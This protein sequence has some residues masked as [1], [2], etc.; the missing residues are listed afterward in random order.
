MKR[1]A[2]F[3]L[4]VLA[5]LVASARGP[6][7]LFPFNVEDGVVISD[8]ANKMSHA[9]ATLINKKGDVFVAHI[10][11]CQNNHEDPSNLTIDLALSKFNIKKYKSGKIEHS[12]LLQTGGSIGEFKQDA[13]IPPYDPFLLDLGDKIRCVFAAR[14]NGDWVVA[15]FDID[16]EDGKPIGFV[17]RCR[18]HYT[19][20]GVKK[21]VTMTSEAFREVYTDLG[22]TNF[23][24]YERPLLDQNFTKHGEWYYN[25]ISS[26]CC[27]GAMPIVVR[28]KDGIDYEILFTCPEFRYGAAEAAMTIEGERVYVIARTSRPA[29][30]A[31][32]GT[33]LGVYALTGQCLCK[34][35][36][37]GDIESRPEFLN[38]EGTVYVMY[39]VK[40]NYLLP[41]GKGANRSRVRL[42]ILNDMGTVERAWEIASPHS[43]QYY[44]LNEYKGDIYLTFGEDRFNRARAKKGNISFVKTE[45]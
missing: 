1:T 21:S 5:S 25:V 30:K 16:S 24:G 35:Y 42:A 8:P 13:N 33:F 28:T 3:I 15:A 45:L 12:V 34:P 23:N 20:N 17:D 22:V 9:S 36:Q 27:A 11:D 44:C 43:I 31:V 40:P 2:L 4:L 14:E 29:K 7:T 38:H 19:H 18:I 37:I 41:N 39:N 6:K 32:R 26:W 10:R